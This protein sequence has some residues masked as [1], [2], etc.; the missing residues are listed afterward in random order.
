MNIKEK[1]ISVFHLLIRDKNFWFVILAVLL[2]SISMIRSF[3]FFD[4]NAVI[5]AIPYAFAWVVL[6]WALTDE[7]I[8]RKIVPYVTIFIAL[9]L[10]KIYW[11]L[12]YALYPPTYEWSGVGHMGRLLGVGHMGRLTPEWLSLQET[13]AFLFALVEFFV[14]LVVFISLWY[15]ARPEDFAGLK[16]KT[17]LLKSKRMLL[18]VISS[19]LMIA[20]YWLWVIAGRAIVELFR[21]SMIYWYQL[22]FYGLPTA[23]ALVI[24]AVVITNI[25]RRAKYVLHG[26][27]G[28]FALVPYLPFYSY[29]Y[30]TRGTVYSYIVLIYAISYFFVFLSLLL[31]TK[32][33]YIEQQS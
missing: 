30:W 6:A 27:V 23:F 22:L 2:I 20:H 11:Y 28:L 18:I 14:M 29:I 24:F 33:K 1:T 15:L 5:F 17:S 26:V 21:Y 4:Y 3:A 8:K 16:T 9:F 31:L 32:T 10:V 12:F 7:S 25:K 13:A 19:F